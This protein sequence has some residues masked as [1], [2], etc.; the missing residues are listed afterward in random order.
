MENN[1][2]KLC[3]Q[4]VREIRALR[5]SGVAGIEIARRYG[6]TKSTISQVVCRKIWQH[7]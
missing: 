6:V 1:L 7:I 5:A 2:A 4:D 3:D